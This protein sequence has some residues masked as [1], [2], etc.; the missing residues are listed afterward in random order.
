MTTAS[1]DPTTTASERKP[2]TGLVW[3]LIVLAAVIALVSSMTVWV[4][5]QALDTDAWTTASTRLLENDQVRGALSVYIVDQLYSNGDVTGRLE[6]RLPPDLAG[7]AAPLAGAL[8]QPAVTATDKL[9]ARPRVQSLWEQVN[10]V[11]HQRLVA[12]L[13]GQPRENVSTDNGTVVLD[14]RSFIIDVGAQLGIGD[15]LDQK[16]PADVGQV[17]VLESDQLAAAQDV[18]KAINALSWLLGIFTFLLWGVA[19]WLA[20][21]WRRVALRGIG[22]SMMV[23]GLLLLVVRRVAGNY[24]VDALTS[25]GSIRDAADATWLIGTTILATIGWAFL[26]YGFSVVGGAWLAGPSKLARSSRD[27]AAPV[28]TDRPG[29][30]WTGLGSAFLLL[31]IWGPTHALHTLLGVTIL[32]GLLAA[33]FELLRRQVVAEQVVVLPD[34]A[35][36]PSPVPAARQMQP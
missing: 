35:P 24:V 17:T 21:G 9:L 31:V 23:V 33:G 8:R 13:E 2:H 32:G 7:L 36:A 15:Q 22:T 18:V 19:L 34:V 12:I 25:G 14:L 16:L 30:A 3:T 4:K 28:L 29:L 11:A 10:R 20:H 6:E 5:R 27:L 26:I 1:V